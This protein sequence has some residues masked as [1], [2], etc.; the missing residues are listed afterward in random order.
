MNSTVQKWINTIAYL[1]MTAVN[2]LANIIPI[3]IGKTGEISEKYPN[4]FTPAPVTFGIWG[5]IYLCTGFFILYQ[6][7]FFDHGLNSDVIR[8]KIGPWFAVSCI[9]NISWLLAWHFDVIWLSVILIA[10]LLVSLF[11]ITKKY[12]VHD[13]NVKDRL[14]VTVGF[15]IYFGWIIAALIADICVFLTEKGQNSF[16]TNVFMTAAVITAGA[17]TGMYIVFGGGRKLSALAIIWAYSGILIKHISPSGYGGKYPAVIVFTIAG[18]V[19][20]LC[21]LI[22]K[23]S[24]RRCCV[25]TN[26]KI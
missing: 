12:R 24:G 11:I 14:C 13:M 2:I 18:I 6:W 8:E 21:S 23:D 17:L 7:G 25:R 1:A 22:L 5:L 26:Q 3:G 19:L 15:D 9:L 10:A 16:G 4:L 20:I